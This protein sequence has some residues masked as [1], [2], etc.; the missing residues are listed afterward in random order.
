MAT[1]PPDHPQEN[2]V[3]VLGMDR[4]GTSAVAALFVAAGFYAGN[5]DDLMPPDRANPRGYYENLRAYDLNEQ[6]LGALD[7]TWFLPPT[8]HRQRKA[9]DWVAPKLRTLL[10]SLTNE[11]NDAPILVKDPRIGVMLGLW[12]PVIDE[13]RLHPVLVLRNPVE[14]A[15]SLNRRDGIPLPFGLAIWQLKMT[16]LLGYLTKRRVTVAR[17]EELVASPGARIDVVAHAAEHV[18]ARYISG[19]APKAAASAVDAELHRNRVS[20]GEL[21]HHLTAIQLKLWRQLEGYSDAPVKRLSRDL[22]L[23]LKHARG[24]ARCEAERQNF[25]RQFDRLQSRVAELEEALASR[26]SEVAP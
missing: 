9:R 17:Y 2:G 12:G 21:I 26:D 22:R 10:E 23:G 19:L 3:V 18:A 8:E 25:M 24:L 14:V 20:D 5:D 13:W 11:A 16:G 15:T 6:I 1:H 7:A 4:S